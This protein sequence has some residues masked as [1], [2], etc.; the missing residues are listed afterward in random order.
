LTIAIEGRKMIEKMQDREPNYVNEI[1]TLSHTLE[2][3]QTGKKS[4]E[5]TFAL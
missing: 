3:E 4:I 5:G 1:A 2:E